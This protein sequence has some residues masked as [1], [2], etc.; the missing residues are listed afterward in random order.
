MLTWWK[1]TIL[2]CASNTKHLFIHFAH[3]PRH[4]ARLVAA[5]STPLSL[6]TLGPCDFN[7]TS[8]PA[9]TSAGGPSA[10]DGPPGPAAAAGGRGSRRNGRPV[11]L[12]QLQFKR[13][14][15]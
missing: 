12:S 2:I 15:A 6:R 5:H 14:N 8:F 13:T 10:M 1:H 7:R 4:H 3:R 11:S 9:T